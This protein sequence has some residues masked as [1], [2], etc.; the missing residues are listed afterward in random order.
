VKTRLK[1]SDITAG[2]A[3]IKSAVDAK[4]SIPAFHSALF[5]AGSDGVAISGTDSNIRASVKVAANV[6]EDGVAA[7]KCSALLGIISGLKGDADLTITANSKAT[8]VSSGRSHY[9]L[10]ALL[11]FP[12]LLEV[13]EATCIS[14]LLAA[15]LRRA[16]QQITFSISNEPL[17][18]PSLSGAYFHAGASRLIIES[19]NG[20]AAAH[21]EIP[22]EHTGASEYAITVPGE[23][24]AP[25]VISIT[26]PI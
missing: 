25:A 7:I 2:A 19:T 18:R 14:V 11:D 20:I 17:T 5:Q 26:R 24:M 8:T 10:P 15:D 23:K 6:E 16:L 4:S 22:A 9:K 12:D 21:V 13:T 3:F 1:V